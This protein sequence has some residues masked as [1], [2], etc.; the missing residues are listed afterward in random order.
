MSAPPDR[1]SIELEIGELILHGLGPLDRHRLQDAL[2][3]K[4][5][6]LLHERGL[7]PAVAAGGEV[8]R[9]DAGAI[10]VAPGSTAETVG[11]QVAQVLHGGLNR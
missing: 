11:L 8:A 9:L 1:P 7:S 10:Q 4:L 2:Q 6:Q 3:Q 5:E